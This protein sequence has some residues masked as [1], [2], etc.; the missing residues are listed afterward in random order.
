MIILGHHIDPDQVANIMLGIVAV[1][2]AFCAVMYWAAGN[3]GYGIA[4]VC[5]AGANIGL[6]MAAAAA[7]KSGML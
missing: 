2:Y 1:E 3:R 6:I 5:Y 4:F 7:A